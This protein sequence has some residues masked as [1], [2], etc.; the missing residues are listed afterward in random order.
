MFAKLPLGVYRNNYSVGRAGSLKIPTQSLNRYLLKQFFGFSHVC[1]PRHSA[2]SVHGVMQR[3][4]QVLCYECDASQQ[5]NVAMQRSQGGYIKQLPCYVFASYQTFLKF[6]EKQAQNSNKFFVKFTKLLFIIYLSFLKI[7]YK[8]FKIS[9][10]FFFIF[11][12][13]FFQDFIEYQSKLMLFS[14]LRCIFSTVPQFFID[15]LS[16][17]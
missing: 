3:L 8:I 6:S 12:Q 16:C 17:F 2:Q 15:I 7:F 11:L 5:C 9:A 13:F 10:K 14:N 1:A 4:H